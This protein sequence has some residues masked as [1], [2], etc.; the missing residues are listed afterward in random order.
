MALAGTRQL[1]SEG[2]VFVHAH[3][4]EGITGSEGR[5]GANGI[6]GGIKDGVGGVNGDVNVDGNGDGGEANEGRERE[7]RRRGDEAQETTN[8]L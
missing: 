1:R 5:E 8:K 4:T 3:R 6:G 2:A 7:G